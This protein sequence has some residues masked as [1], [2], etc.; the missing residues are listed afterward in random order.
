MGTGSP[1]NMRDRRAST[2][3]RERTPS[4]FPDGSSPPGR[5]HHML[6]RPFQRGAFRHGAGQRDAVRE[7]ER[8]QPVGERALRGVCRPT[9]KSALAVEHFAC[10]RLR[11]AVATTSERKPVG[12][13]VGSRHNAALAT[14]MPSSSPTC[15]SAGRARRNAQC[16]RAASRTR[17][18]ND[19]HS[20]FRPRSR[21]R[22]RARDDAARRARSDPPKRPPR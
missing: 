16:Y 20:R 9:R 6:R 11:F 21:H 13:P 3:L 15:G 5:R 17:E 1:Q 22:C 7:S 4:P 10:L 8:Q 18:S 2:D 14:E 12:A 19:G